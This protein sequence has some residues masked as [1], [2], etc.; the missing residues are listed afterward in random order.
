MKNFW[1]KWF[2]SAS[3]GILGRVLLIVLC[4][5][6]GFVGSQYISVP[7]DKEIITGAG[8]LIVFIIVLLAFFSP[9]LLPMILEWSIMK[10]NLNFKSQELE[11][12][13]LKLK[14]KLQQQ[15]K[16]SLTDQDE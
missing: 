3:S 5:V 14:L 4:L 1:S 11:N 13:N 2:V 15:E 6:T 8:F 12:E 10:K 16:P 9:L 7:I